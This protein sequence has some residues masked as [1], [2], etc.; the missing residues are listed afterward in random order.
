MA[1]CAQM[2]KAELRLL[3]S[4]RL[5]ELAKSLLLVLYRKVESQKSRSFLSHGTTANRSTP[6]LRH[7]LPKAR[8]T[9]QGATCL[10]ATHVETCRNHFEIYGVLLHA[11]ACWLPLFFIGSFQGL[12]CG[13]QCSDICSYWPPTMRDFHAPAILD[14][15]LQCLISPSRDGFEPKLNNFEW[16][17]KFRTQSVNQLR[18]TSIFI[19]LTY[20]KIQ[21][22]F[23]NEV[24][25][26]KTPQYPSSRTK[27]HLPSPA[28]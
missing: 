27:K 26:T 2:K 25:P 11:D 22:P 28:R 5:R 8:I 15:C 18:L 14:R 16:G 13:I 20:S 7:A 1:S 12:K 6:P 24:G 23:R 19:N 10:K 9:E 4:K 17:G 3:V 21:K